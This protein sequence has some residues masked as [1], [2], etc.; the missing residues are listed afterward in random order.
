MRQPEKPIFLPFDAEASSHTFPYEVAIPG[1]FPLPQS[2]DIV[3]PQI[4]YGKR[5]VA[6][7]NHFPIPFR[8][9]RRLFGVYIICPDKKVSLKEIC[10]SGGVN[11]TKHN[12]SGPNSQISFCLF[13]AYRTVAAVPP[14]ALPSYTANRMSARSTIQRLRSIMQ[15]GV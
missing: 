2:A 9:I 1:R 14:P 8:K 12:V 11:A 3:R 6:I 13:C 4:P 10:F 15:W 5:M 7:I